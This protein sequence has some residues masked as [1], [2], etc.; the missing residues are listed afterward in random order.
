[1][2]ILRNAMAA[3]K[4]NKARNGFVAAVMLIIITIS[5]TALIINN[6]AIAIRDEQKAKYGSKVT[7]QLSDDALKKYTTSTQS[8]GT[9]SNAISAPELDNELMLNLSKSEYVKDTIFETGFSANSDTLKPVEKNE[10]NNMISSSAVRTDGS[11][12]EDMPTP[13]YNVRGYSKNKESTIL[14]EM[15]RN[16]L[17]GTVPADKMDCMISNELAKE[18]NLKVGDSITIKALQYTKEDA[19][20]SDMT[21]KISGIYQNIPASDSGM[22]FMGM[23]DIYMLY[24]GT[25][26][27]AFNNNAYLNTTYYLNS[28]DDLDAFNDEARQLGLAEDYDVSTDKAAYEQAVGPIDGMSQ[29]SLL[30]LII[31]L[32]LG[33]GLLVLLNIMNIRDRN[34]EIGI[35][36]SL[37]MRKTH[38]ILQM[39]AEPILVVICM[40]VIGGFAG[41]LIAQPISDNLLAHQLQKGQEAQMNG[42]AIM[43]SM[44]TMQVDTIDEMQVSLDST[45]LIQ[46]FGVSILL[47]LVSGLISSLYI[48]RYEPMEILSER[49]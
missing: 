13:E 22:M 2:N 36:R 38:V 1:M 37:G 27:S 39:I 44:S 34:Y 7:I 29:V 43:I 24:E 17:E 49:R 11:T 40:F 16:L 28:P 25:I 31:V 6:T 21:L 26:D 10:D 14:S 18:N 46:V 5:C 41:T 23:E 30:F 8:G 35:L 48:V 45:T 12:N 9:M 32:S 47:V 3:L 42:G 4:R 20:P 33:S 15:N 19:E